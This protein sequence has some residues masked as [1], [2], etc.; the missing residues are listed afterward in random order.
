MSDWRPKQRPAS[1]RGVAFFVDS[2]DVAGGRNT[3]AHEH[4]YNEKAATTE[5][6]GRKG[7]TFSVDGYVVG[8]E[9]E[10]ARDALT[11][12]LDARGPG[13]LVHPYFGTRRVAVVTYRIRQ[14]RTDGGMAT[15]SIEF[16][17]TVSEPILPTT[18]AAPASV[19]ASTISAAKVAV[20]A[21][22]LASRSVA[23]R[24][25]DS[26]L[27]TFDAVGALAL[28]AGMFRVLDANPIS[29][30][31]RA[32]FRRVTSGE[33]STADRLAEYMADSVE[34][35]FNAFEDAMLSATG[36]PLDPVALILSL[37][38]LDLGPRPIAA[39][40]RRL[41]EQRDY[42]ALKNLITR[43]AI[44]SASTAILSRTFENFERAVE[45]RS[46]LTDVIDAHAET[47][48]DGAFPALTNLRSGLVNA[49][50]GEDS[51]LPRLQAYTP[52]SVVPSVVLAHR[53]YGHLDLELDLVDRNRIRHPGFVPPDELEVL[54]ND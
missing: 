19:V 18:T 9:Y 32:E 44:T 24:V 50:P 13:E 30:A 21:E 46:L 42:D 5:D 51:N 26:D 33:L 35:L 47:V 48:A 3:V 41:V 15:F 1:F 27:P 23:F 37:A 31:I 8:T 49:V 2:A 16:R 10:A 34:V 45:V 54:T 29:A 4:P 6:M 7:Q 40:P 12:A 28:Y 39:T 22:F 36:L 14:T 25:P 43:L 20:R 38:D 52:P 11:R 53:L 17:E